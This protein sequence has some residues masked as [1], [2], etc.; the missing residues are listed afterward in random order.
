MNSTLRTVAAAAAF[1][2]A[3]S[4]LPASAASSP[5]AQDQSRDQDHHETTQTQHPDY[6]KNRFYTLGNREGYQDYN[7]KQQRKTHDHK[8]RN[9][10]DRS[11]HDLGY[12]QGW[13]GHL[14]YTPDADRR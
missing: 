8:Y 7:K 13:N 9:D 3:I 1:S 2:I 4:A 11:A 10:D 6:S 5:A 14:G 12:Q